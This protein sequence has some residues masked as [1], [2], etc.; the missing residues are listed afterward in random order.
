MEKSDSSE[1]EMLKQHIETLKEV[2]DFKKTILIMDRGYYSLE[3]KLFLEKNG[4]NYIFR[5]SSK[6]Y[7]KEI[8]NMKNSD[9]NLKIQN[10]SK[11]REKNKR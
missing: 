6:V 10:T 5:L 4:I 9:E 2:I 3:L 7:E 11:R 8:N 1:R